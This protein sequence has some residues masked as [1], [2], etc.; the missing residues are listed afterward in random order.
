MA[1]SIAVVLSPVAGIQD[2][3]GCS[4]SAEDDVKED[5]VKKDPAAFMAKVD[6]SPDFDPEL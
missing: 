1:T 2:V 4:R 6:R 3:G 5:D